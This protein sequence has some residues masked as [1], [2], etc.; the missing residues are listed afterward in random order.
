MKTITLMN[1]DSEH[2][3]TLHIVPEQICY[4]S[5]VIVMAK[6]RYAIRIGFGGTWPLTVYYDNEKDAYGIHNVLLEAIQEARS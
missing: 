3:D 1:C 6:D 5:D 2:G 4:V